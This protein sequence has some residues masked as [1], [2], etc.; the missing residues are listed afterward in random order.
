MEH[1]IIINLIN[2]Y[3][4]ITIFF[5]EFFHKNT[6]TFKILNKTL[7]ICLIFCQLEYFNRYFILQIHTFSANHHLLRKLYYGGL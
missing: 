7:F 3:F 4:T 1:K 2:G 6:Q 5:Q